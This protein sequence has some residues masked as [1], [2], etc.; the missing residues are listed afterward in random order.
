M[1]EASEKEEGAWYAFHHG[2]EVQIMDSGD[3]FHRT[4]GQ[5]TPLP[6]LADLARKTRWRL[7]TMSITLQGNPRLVELVASKSPT[8]IPPPPSPTQELARPSATP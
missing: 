4:G 7:A 5:F 8:S 1:K 2:Y 3:A 6:P